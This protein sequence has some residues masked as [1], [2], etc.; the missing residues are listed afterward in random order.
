MS[1]NVETSPSPLP[2]Q[3]DGFDLLEF[4]IRHRTRVL[5]YGALLVIAL[6]IFGLYQFA[7][8]REIANAEEAFSRAA[9]AEDYQKIID[10]WPKLP[11]AAS[12]Q[13]LLAAEQRRA[14]KLDESNALLKSFIEKHPQHELL[15]G[16]WTSLAVNAE[17]SGKLDEAM[18]SYQKVIATWPTSFSAP[19]AWI[20]KARVLQE[21]GKT[22]DARHA[23]ETVISNFAESPFAG[24]A[25]RETQRLKK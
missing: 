16:A 22:D 24:E 19:V 14:G 2:P 1:T 18:N 21:Q 13:L 3:D 20:G 5:L 23:Y 8:Q 6:V 25:M 9:K 17:Q 15:P 4:W 10:T 12:A 11:A 7:H